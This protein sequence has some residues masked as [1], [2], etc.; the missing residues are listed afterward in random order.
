MKIRINKTTYTVT[1]TRNDISG[2]RNYKVYDLRHVNTV[3]TLVHNTT[4][5]AFTLLGKRCGHD[6]MVTIENRNVT[7]NA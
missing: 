3:K 2:N 5:N 6:T 1:E 4:W 7:I